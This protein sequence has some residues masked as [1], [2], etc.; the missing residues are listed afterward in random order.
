M[1]NSIMRRNYTVVFKSFLSYLP[2]RIFVIL[3]ALVIVPIFAY[4][5]TTTQM[6]VFQ[7]SIGILNLVCTASTDWIAKSVLRFYERYKHAGELDNFFSNIMIIEM[8]AFTCIF[9]GYFIFK[10]I[11]AQKF[12]IPENIF[13]MTLIL[14]VPCGIRQIFYQLLRILKMT[15]LYTVSIII[16]QISL[17]TLFFAFSHFIENVLSILLAMVISICII[18]C[19]ILYKL[20]LKENLTFKFNEKILRNIIIYAIPLFF[21]NICIWLILHFGK[22]AFQFNKDFVNTAIVGTAWFFVT[23]ALTPLFSLLMFAVFPLIVRRFEKKYRVKEFMTAVLNAYIVMFLPFVCVLSF[24]SFD[25][26]KI[27]F[28]EEYMNLGVLFPFC[29]ITIFVHE[30]M[31]L[32]NMKYHLKNRTYIETIIS[33]VVA[34]ICV[35][36]NLVLIKHWSIYGFGTAMVSSIILLFLANSLVKFKYLDYLVPKKH[37]KCLFMSLLIA[38]ISFLIPFTIFFAFKNNVTNIIQIILFF[39]IYV[40]STFK[41]K[42]YIL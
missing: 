33:F 9:A 2:S 6:S 30:F 1:Q 10:G 35:A 18:D 16:Y 42:K 41:V 36:L 23:N 8:L 17:I 40:L 25:I 31:K 7:I 38:I 20:K 21:T 19:L 32:A 4:F 29:A 22:F 27:A 15:V 14:V 24:Y 37:I 11:V 5:L 34:I 28:K 12:Y 3:N 39:T 13:L 26:A